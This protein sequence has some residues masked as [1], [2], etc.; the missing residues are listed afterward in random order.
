MINAYTSHDLVAFHITCRAEV[1]P[2]AIDLLT[3]IAGRPRIDADEL[4]RERGVVIQE[5]ARANDQP[6]VVAELPDRP[7]GVRRP[8][9]RAPGARARGAPA[10]ASRREADRRASASA[11]GR[12]AAAARSSS[13]T[14]TTC[15][16]RQSSTSC[17][18]RFPSLP[19]SR[20]R[21]SPRRRS[22][23][24]CSSSSAT[25]TSR[26][27]GCVYR[28]PID[29]RDRRAARRA[30]RSTRRCSAARWARACSTRSASSAACATRSGR[31]TTASPTR[32]CSALGAGPR[33]EQVPRGLRAHARDRRRAARATGRARRRSSARAP[34]PAGASCWPSRTPARSRA[35]PR[36]SRSSTATSI[37]PDLAIDARRRASRF[38]EVVAVARGISEEL[39]VACVG[40]TRPRFLGPTP[41][42]VWQAGIATIRSIASRAAAAI[43]RA[44]RAPRAR[45][46]AARRA[47]SAA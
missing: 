15:R 25:P 21:T 47:A 27:C 4:E 34:T 17:F 2:A 19:A 13:A 9:A 31:T 33:L 43:S 23:R 8:P 7:R 29:P 14:P 41:R 16:E 44:A 20:R 22:S 28:P 46:R 37:D 38:D 11:A 18:G 6:A 30:R 36:S 39:A 1:A 3:D 12:P 42:R 40:R 24:A 26:T 10:R 32:R 45:R 5:I 35:T